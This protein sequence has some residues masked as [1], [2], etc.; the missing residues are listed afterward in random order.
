MRKRRQ[1]FS[2]NRASE[3]S[4]GQ[5]YPQ[6]SQIVK[7]LFV[8][9]AKKTLKNLPTSVGIIGSRVPKE[10]EAKRSHRSVIGSFSVTP[11]TTREFFKRNPPS[12]RILQMEK[13]AS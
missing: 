12:N 2:K 9:K 4:L 10:K 13:L 11:V 1:K 6:K 5:K 3:C 7:T 8:N